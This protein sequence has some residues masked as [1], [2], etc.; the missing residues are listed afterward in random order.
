VTFRPDLRYHQAMNLGRRQD[1]LLMQIAEQY[2]DVSAVPY[3]EVY[4]QVMALAEG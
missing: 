3:D 1:T 4:E 2:Q